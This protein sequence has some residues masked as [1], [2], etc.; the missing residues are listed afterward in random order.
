MKTT[1]Q[2]YRKDI[3]GIRAIAIIAVF[4]YHVWPDILPGGYL[5]VDIFFTISGYLITSIIIRENQ[6]STF[7][8]ISFFARRIIRLFPALILLLISLCFAGYFFLLPDEYSSLG[9]HIAGASIFSSNFFLLSEVGYFDIASSKKILLHL[10]SLAIEE[11]FY[12]IW[13]VL[14]WFGYK[15]KHKSKFNIIHIG[16]ITLISLFI[17]IFFNYTN[18]NIAFYLPF[19]RFWQISIGALIITPQFD[20]IKSIFNK[21]SYLNHLSLLSLF[22]LIY[23]FVYND[24]TSS[25]L[26]SLNSMIASICT[27][28]IILTESSTINLKLLSSKVLVYIGLISY[29]LYLWHWPIIVFDRLITKPDKLNYQN[30]LSEIL[31]SLL[32]TVI[33][34]HLLET[35]L[36]KLNQIK[37]INIS[38]YLLVVL[39]SI[40]FIGDQIQHFNIQ[41]KISLDPQMSEFSNAK[42]DWIYPGIVYTI[43]RPH[44]VI[45]IKDIPIVKITTQNPNETLFL[46]DSNIEQYYPRILKISNSANPKINSSA[47]ITAGGCLPIP[48]IINNT[49]LYCE[50]VLARV[51][52][53]AKRIEVKNIVI[54]AQWYGYF[55]T[56]KGSHYFKNSKQ[57]ISTEDKVLHTVFLEFKKFLQEIGRNKNIFI[58]LN[59]PIGDEF[60]PI[61]MVARSLSV[62]PFSYI[63]NDFIRS[64][65]DAQMKPINQEFYNLA[66]DLNAT[67]I[68]PMNSLCDQNICK[69]TWNS[70]P[71]Y[72]DFCHMKASYV[73][74]YASFI[75][76]V[77]FSN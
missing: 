77:M 41:A 63:Q 9:R 4:I 65:F 15:F 76:P 37:K 1:S 30:Y 44:R 39:F 50:N 51:L 43:L 54:A 60:D 69:T 33:T 31:I 11:Q 29:P 58:V 75:D 21:N 59:I 49:Y 18:K 34:F 28:L 57:V 20:R 19:S 13:P 55:Y 2:F 38:K 61:S 14:I 71:I 67:V 48:N 32:L 35:P 74:N 23:L 6:N 70:K 3:D 72:K 16:I 25:S 8:F 42:N 12:L 73:T 26:N 64:P 7:S 5:G 53:Y 46:G 68:D 47:F 62:N 45:E 17:Y 24:K 56:Q 52:E 66:K 10:W 40:G 36:L 27:L 22:T